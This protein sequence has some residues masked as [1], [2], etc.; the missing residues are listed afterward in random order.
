MHLLSLSKLI[1][2]FKPDA[3]IIDPISNLISIGSVNE[4]RAML[5]RLID[6]LKVNNITGLFTSLTQQNVSATNELTEESVSSLVDTWITLRDVEAVGERNRGLYILKSRGMG[7]SNAVKEFVI[8][9][10]GITL[11]DT[12]I[13]PEGLLTG[14][15]R[16]AYRKTKSLQ[17]VKKQNDIERRD[18]EIERKKKI[19][20][21]NIENMRIEFESVLEELNKLK[22]EEKDLWSRAETEPAG[23]Q[24]KKIKKNK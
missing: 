18:R 22:M 23:K 16:E 9:D 10:D 11:L 12:E 1:R 14:T 6:L 7:H 24:T 3:V 5:V 4:V 19:L 2:D 15:A 17:Q 20:E 21:S 8:S 13:G